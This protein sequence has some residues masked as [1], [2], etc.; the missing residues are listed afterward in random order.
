MNG[1]NEVVHS[2]MNVHQLVKIAV[3]G[4]IAFLLML[5]RM[6]IFF[7]PSFMD[8]DVSEMPGLLASFSMGPVAGFFVILLKI[9]LKLMMSGTTTQYVGEISNIIVSSALVVTAGFIY[10]R[11]RTFRNAIFAMAIGVIA[12]AVTATISNYFVIFPLYGKLMGISLDEF[13]NAVREV[14]PLVKDF[15]SLMVFS[16]AP[17]NLVKGLLTAVLTTVLYKRLSPI[18]KK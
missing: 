1:R 6:P 7:A 10:Q 13:A 8:L 12:M 17:F 3:L 2:K 15:K 16:I 9:V 5:V 11:R 4:V 18:L 14:N